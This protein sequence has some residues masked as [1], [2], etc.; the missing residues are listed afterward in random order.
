MFDTHGNCIPVDSEAQMLA[1]LKGEE[2]ALNFAMRESGKAMALVDA[3]S[4][5][6][7]EAVEY[8]IDALEWSP[9]WYDFK[10]YTP[11]GYA[12]LLGRLHTVVMLVEEYGDLV[13]L[14]E[15]DEPIRLIDQRNNMGPHFDPIQGWWDGDTPLELAFKNGHMRVASFLLAR[16]AGEGDDTMDVETYNSIVEEVEAFDTKQAK[17][18]WAQVRATW[19]RGRRFV[20]LLMEA[21]AAR[22]TEPDPESV[23]FIVHMMQ[24]PNERVLALR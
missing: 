3:A 16:G 10:N 17:A 7:N 21:V 18:H 5:G 8:M 20:N 13:A 15:D 6:W 9:L 14:D 22:H 24:T 23:A 12:S 1:V 2:G 11:L 19:V 4:H